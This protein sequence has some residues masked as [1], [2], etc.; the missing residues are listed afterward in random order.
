MVLN[1]VC[2][3]HLGKYVLKAKA[4]PLHIKNIRQDVRND[5]EE[6]SSLFQVY[7]NVSP[8]IV[9]LIKCKSSLYCSISATFIKEL[10]HP[11]ALLLGDSILYH[12]Q[13]TPVFSKVARFATCVFLDRKVNDYMMTLIS[14]K[15]RHLIFFPLIT[16]NVRAM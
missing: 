11:E 4:D 13:S 6:S 10:D 1:M 2:S 8:I 7:F 3:P 15:T 5:I 9:I 16:L 12:V 14:H